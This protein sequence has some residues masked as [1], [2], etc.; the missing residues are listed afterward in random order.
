MNRKPKILIVDDEEIS[1][2]FF[3]AAFSTQKYQVLTASLGE[4]A[5]ALLEHDPDIDVILLDIMMPGLDG[6]EVLEILKNNPK[7]SGIKVIMLS[8]QE[9]TSYKVKA[10][11]AGAADYV[12]KPFQKDELLARIETQVKLKRMEQALVE[13]RT[14]LRTLIDHLPDAIYV[15]DIE[16]RFVV[17][18][19][20]AAQYLGANSID[21]VVGRTDY[22]F[23]SAESATQYHAEEQ[24]LFQSGQPLLNQEE[25]TINQITGNMQ[26]LLVTKV[27]LRDGHGQIIGL[28]GVNRDISEMK[29]MQAQM[30][31]SQKLA[32]L[33]T[34]AAG[35]AHEINSPLQVITG[36]S[37]N[38]LTR[39]QQGPLDSSFLA[40]KLD[41]IQRNG[42]RCAEI[43]RALRTYGHAIT[44]A[45]EPYDLN[46]LIR[47]TLLLIEHQ[48]R[49]WGN[50]AII[51]N[52]ASDLPA[53]TC[54]RNKISQILINLLTNARDAM[55]YGGDITLCT[56]YD[57][58]AGRINLRITDTGAGIPEEV[59]AK[60]FDPFFTTK[61]IGQGTGLGL[62]IVAGIVQAHGGEI[63]VE[64]IPGQG[65]TF[66]LSFPE[67]GPILI[68]LP[69]EGQGRFADSA[70]PTLLSATRINS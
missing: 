63:R 69:G 65:T 44:E 40:R 57:A 9:E 48:L 30:L 8:A 51:T 41:I 50:I 66:N 35:V 20:A 67:A 36:T 42:W 60:I 28:V 15:K 25:N 62:S 61:P 24:V 55:P 54:D 34:L 10:F 58:Q 52:L 37:E 45:A 64:S 11:T 70:Y 12:V 39:L 26:V 5:L 6:F 38:L 68:P 32:D 43:V 13:E 21:E 1:R 59:Q 47:D 7:T 3:M 17:V 27:P 33:G 53:F 49:N 22:D 4:D 14:L 31:A 2:R 18:N 29:Q 56:G 19:P 46:L 23:F 16:S